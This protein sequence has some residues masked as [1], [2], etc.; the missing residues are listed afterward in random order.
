MNPTKSVSDTVHDLKRSSSLFINKNLFR[1][2]FSW[3]EGYGGFSY[4]KSQVEDVFNYVKNQ[5]E[6]HKKRTFREEYTEFL[7]K[8]QIDYN[9]KYLFDFFEIS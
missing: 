5:E 7:K 8:S 6:H 4:S 9:E 2:M 1:G 3:Q